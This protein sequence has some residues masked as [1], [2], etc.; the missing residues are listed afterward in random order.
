VLSTILLTNVV[1]ICYDYVPLHKRS[2]NADASHQNARDEVSPMKFNFKIILYV[3]VF[4]TFSFIISCSRSQEESSFSETS[5]SVS[6]TEPE[7][8]PVSN[9]KLPVIMFSNHELS[10]EE[11][12]TTEVTVHLLDG[13]ESILRE[14]SVSCIYGYLDE[15]KE[16][17]KDIADNKFT[18]SISSDME[19]DLITVTIFGEGG[20]SA[21]SYIEVKKVL[22]EKGMS[23]FVIRR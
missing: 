15:A 7:D 19:E 10:F 4:L 8:L 22:N 16:V 9:V 11:L 14:Y 2:Q 1:E 13:E 21:S 23:V 17:R 5:E 3:L 6:E 18:Y 12:A 20:Y